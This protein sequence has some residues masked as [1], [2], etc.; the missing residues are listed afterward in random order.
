MSSATRTNRGFEPTTIELSSVT[1][2][3]QS[4]MFR[5]DA[6]TTIDLSGAGPPDINNGTVALSLTCRLGARIINTTPGAGFTSADGPPQ[7]AA[8]TNATPQTSRRPRVIV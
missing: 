4:P 5:H 7:A 3:I 8:T 2:A 1:S 6:A